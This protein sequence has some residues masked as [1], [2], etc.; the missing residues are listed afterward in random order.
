MSDFNNIS[1]NFIRNRL[2]NNLYFLS[3][4]FY[5]RS[6]KIE[7][8]YIIINTYVQQHINAMHG[9]VFH[10]ELKPYFEHRQNFLQIPTI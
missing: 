3:L 9:S 4:E 5:Y 6:E 1:N 2:K 10:I 7:T 8:L